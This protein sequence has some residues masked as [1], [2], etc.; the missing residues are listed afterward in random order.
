MAFL[1]QNTNITEH[2]CP[3]CADRCLS[4]LIPALSRQK[5]AHSCEVKICIALPRP[6]RGI[7]RHP[8]QKERNRREKKS[9][10]KKKEGKKKHYLLSK[11]RG[12]YR[13]P[14]RKRITSKK[15]AKRW[16]HTLLKPTLVPRFAL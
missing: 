4:A 11:K 5:Q 13:K 6:S 3:G 14:Y 1:T 12:K 7:Q 16:H 2:K 8:V 10:E 9:K 15:E